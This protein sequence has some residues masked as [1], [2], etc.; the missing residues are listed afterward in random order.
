MGKCTNATQGG[1]AAQK[2]ISSTPSSHRGKAR[3]TGD[4][5]HDQ[6]DDVHSLEERILQMG[7]PSKMPFR[8]M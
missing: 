7:A 3:D 4:A 6:R 2:G 8:F 1:A 5:V